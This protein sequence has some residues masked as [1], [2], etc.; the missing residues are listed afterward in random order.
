MTSQWTHRTDE[1]VYCDRIWF[2]TTKRARCTCEEK[3]DCQG[4]CEDDVIRHMA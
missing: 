4:D 2:S 1:L 3:T